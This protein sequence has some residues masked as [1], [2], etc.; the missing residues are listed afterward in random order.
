MAVGIRTPVL[1]SGSAPVTAVA[2]SRSALL[3]SLPMATG[4]ALLVYLVSGFSLRLALAITVSAGAAVS[5]FV[6]RRA[7]PAER[8]QLHVR[9]FVGLI[10]GVIATAAYDLTRLAIWKGFGTAFQP[11]DIFGRFGTLLAGAGTAHGERLVVGIAYH[12][13]NGLGFAVAYM[14]LVR[15][16]ELWSGL[17]WAAMLETLML[18]LYPQGFGVTFSQEFVGISIAGH[19]AYGTALGIGGGRLVARE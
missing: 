1:G 12:W 3:V 8:A 7:G 2:A 10:C 18:S 16:P 9:V 14:L 13:A 11:F 17:A 6:W 19:A 15:R 5:A 4:A